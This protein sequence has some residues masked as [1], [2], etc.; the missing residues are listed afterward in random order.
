MPKPPGSGSDEPP[1]AG[2]AS[3][4]DQ[5][6]SPADVLHGE[7]DGLPLLK[8]QTRG[9]SISICSNKSRACAARIFDSQARNAF[10]S[11]LKIRKIEIVFVD[12]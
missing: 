11:H 2:T 5:P 8:L 3:R 9:Q 1:P 7:R 6:G 4:S 10:R 12:Q